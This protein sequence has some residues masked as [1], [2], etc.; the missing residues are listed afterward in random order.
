MVRDVPLEGVG[1]GPPAAFFGLATAG[2][3]HLSTPERCNLALL[4]FDQETFQQ[5]VHGLDG[6]GLEEPLADGTGRRSIRC[7][8]SG[9]GPAW[10]GSSAS[11]SGDLVPLLVEALAHRTGHS[12]RLARPPGG[13]F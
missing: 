1:H 9:C 4:S 7:A 8:F 11:L 6:P 13:D 3:I 5:W 10:A 2:E 12:E